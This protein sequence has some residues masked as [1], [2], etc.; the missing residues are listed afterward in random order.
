M[1]VVVTVESHVTD[2]Q[3]ILRLLAYGVVVVSADWRVV[4]A[5]PEGERMIGSKGA[6]IW[7]R[8]PDLEHTAFASGFRYAMKDRT[9]L[10]SES[11]LPSP[12][13]TRRASGSIAATV[14]PVR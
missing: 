9:E 7:D 6:T 1:P 4:Y 5:N 2:A 10:L 11:A 3:M 12:S 14:T 8:C 13:R